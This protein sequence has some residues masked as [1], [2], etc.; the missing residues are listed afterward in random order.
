[1]PRPRGKKDRGKTASRAACESCPDFP[2][3]ATRWRCRF[4]ADERGHVVHFLITDITTYYPP[5]KTNA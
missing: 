4:H 5:E 1:M 2:P 3:G